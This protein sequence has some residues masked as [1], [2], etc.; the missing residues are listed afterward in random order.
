MVTTA[1]VVAV[2]EAEAMVDRMVED[3]TIPADQTGGITK[4]CNASEMK[5]NKKQ[6]SY[7]NPIIELLKT[8]IHPPTN[9]QTF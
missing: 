1:A 6:I 5:T 3:K 4:R 2:A 8:E 7:T 9:C